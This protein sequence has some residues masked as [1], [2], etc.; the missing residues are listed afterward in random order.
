MVAADIREGGEASCSA[1]DPLIS[2]L[3]PPAA[4]DALDLE[5]LAQYR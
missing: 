5:Q 4:H 1:T 2:L 3:Q